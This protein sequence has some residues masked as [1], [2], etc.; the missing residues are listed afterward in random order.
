M[1]TVFEYSAVT[2]DTR[3]LLLDAAEQVL[4][5][6]GLAGVSLRRVTAVAG[7]N[8]AAVNYT[9]GSK[10][11]LLDALLVRVMEPVLLERTR[12]LDE[13][14]RTPGH[15]VDDL[16]RA[17]LESM[18]RVDKR[19]VAL[20]AEVSVKPRLGGDERFEQTRRTS[21]QTGIDQMTAALTP[22]L[23]GQ[24]PQALG[25]R[26]ERMLKMATIQVLDGTSLA[27]KYELE[28]GPDEQDLID[29]LVAFFSAGLSALNPLTKQNSR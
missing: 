19:H 4:L 17:L 5:E 13:V 23:P 21:V 1:Q 3:T 2:R 14:V 16:V 20:Y 29:E 15:T 26:V 11:A 9:F 22:L 27:E 8:V 28:P 10:E 24:S 18:L 25:Y 6:D 7:V 12:Q